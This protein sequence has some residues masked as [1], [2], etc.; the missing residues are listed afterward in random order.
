MSVSDIEMEDPMKFFDNW[1]LDSDD[2]AAGR[3]VNMINDLAR[4]L[5]RRKRAA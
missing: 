1:L 4:E 3:E 2:D 5:C